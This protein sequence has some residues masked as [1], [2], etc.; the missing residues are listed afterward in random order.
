[1]SNALL[2]DIGNSSIKWTWLAA[3]AVVGKVNSQVHRDQDFSQLLDEHWSEMRTPDTIWVANVA[4]PAWPQHLSSWTRQFWGI[5]PIYVET[6]PAAFGV[7]AGYV[8]YRLLGVDR[9]LAMIVDCGTAATIDVVGAHGQHLGGYIL[10]GV[11]SSRRALLEF[12]R[13]PRVRHV[14]VAS[15]IGDDTAT[16][17]ELGGRL[18]IAGVIKHAMNIVEVKAPAANLFLAGSEADLLR[19]WLPPETRWTP[20]LVLEGLAHYAAQGN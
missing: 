4:G 18:A 15:D 12:T 16:A 8:D 2:V 9:W 20:H 19:R 3:T 11:D 1:M 6:E 5:S 7:Q 13:I 14:D 17:I 10:P